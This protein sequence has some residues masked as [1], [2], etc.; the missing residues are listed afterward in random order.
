[1]KRTPIE[2]GTSV[3]EHAEEQVGSRWPDNARPERQLCHRA[4]AHGSAKVAGEGAAQGSSQSVLNFPRG[5]AKNARLGPLAA[6]L[7]DGASSRV[8][9][10][11]AR[12]HREAGPNERRSRGI[13]SEEPV[14]LLYGV[15][16]RVVWAVCHEAMLRLWNDDAMGLAGLCFQSKKPSALAAETHVPCIF[17][18]VSLCG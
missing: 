18:G 6:R 10:M 16:W 15:R 17:R 11:E 4:R 3:M 1:M 5:S 9:R 14:H 2:L 13:L 12:T 7:S 8:W